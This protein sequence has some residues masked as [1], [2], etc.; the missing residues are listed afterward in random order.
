MTTQNSSGK[1]SL[2]SP[3]KWKWCVAKQP[4]LCNAMGC[5]VLWD[6]MWRQRRLVHGNL[7]EGWHWSGWCW[8]RFFYKEHIINGLVQERRNSI[9]LAMELCLSYTNPLLWSKGDLII[10][11]RWLWDHHIFIMGILILFRWHF[12][13]DLFWYYWCTVDVFSTDQSWFCTFP[14]SNINRTEVL[15]KHDFHIC[16]DWKCKNLILSVP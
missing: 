3:W 10:K 13:D 5:C 7:L 12:L 15:I 8:C 1:L 14:I 2:A 4:R 11:V 16:W 9:A 6:E